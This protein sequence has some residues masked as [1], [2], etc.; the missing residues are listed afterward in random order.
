MV[1]YFNSAGSICSIAYGA[2]V[3]WNSAAFLILES[4]D[5][6]LEQ[7]PLT[8]SEISW[9]CSLIGLGGMA[10]TVVTG[11]ICDKFGRRPGLLFNAFP[12]LAN[13]LLI[14]IAKNAWY[15][16]A[17]RFL[18]GMVGGGVFAVVPLLVGEISEDR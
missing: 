15:L 10:G 13:W 12:L 2:S 11:W 3:G 5:S 18:T 4:A 17:S 9:A 6:P 16:Y 8:V 14:I 1:F 7:G